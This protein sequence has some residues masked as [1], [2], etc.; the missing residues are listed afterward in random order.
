MNLVLLESHGR[1][2]YHNGNY[3]GKSRIKGEKN[4]DENFQLFCKIARDRKF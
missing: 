1:V 3:F 2:E 4:K